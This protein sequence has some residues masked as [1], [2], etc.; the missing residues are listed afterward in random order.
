MNSK[1]IIKKFKLEEISK[2]PAIVMLAKRSSGRCWTSNLLKN[3]NEQTTHEQTT[4]EQIT[5]DPITCNLI[6]NKH[7]A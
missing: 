7:L 6:T 2:N 1:L 4:H 3:I 5:C